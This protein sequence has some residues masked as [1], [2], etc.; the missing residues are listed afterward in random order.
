[1]SFSESFLSETIQ[2]QP[3]RAR[4]CENSQKPW[5]QVMDCREQGWLLGEHTTARCGRHTPF[6]RGW[7]PGGRGSPG[8]VPADA[9]RPL[10]HPRGVPFHDN[11][12]WRRT[13]NATGG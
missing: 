4:S 7:W 11:S 3:W 10:D 9:V 12:N 1:M 5:K 2:W 6:A 8:C 13:G